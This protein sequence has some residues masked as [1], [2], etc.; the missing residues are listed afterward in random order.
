MLNCQ[1]MPRLRQGDAIFVRIWVD[2]QR[3][4]N[5]NLDVWRRGV[6]LNKA[7][8]YSHW[9]A[10]QLFKQARRTMDADNPCPGLYCHVRDEYGHVFYVWHREVVHEQSHQQRREFDIRNYWKPRTIEALCA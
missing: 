9:H 3:G 4:S 6:L 5:P 1:V 8:A 7:R 10:K 2:R